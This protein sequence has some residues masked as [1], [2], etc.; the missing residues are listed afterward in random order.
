MG[1]ERRTGDGAALTAVADAVRAARERFEAVAGT[2]VEAVTAAE[3]DGSGWRL[4]VEVV[5]VRRIPDST[6]IVADYTVDLDGEGNLTGYR[7]RSRHV[8]GRAG[9]G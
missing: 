1:R 6:S 2:P 4:A 5:E 3:R 8:R 7:R 9:G